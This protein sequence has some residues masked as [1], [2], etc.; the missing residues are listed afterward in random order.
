MQGTLL[1][2]QTG[3]KNRA[4]VQSVREN[5]LNEEKQQNPANQGIFLQR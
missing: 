1:C 2:K 3:K 4:G 5:L